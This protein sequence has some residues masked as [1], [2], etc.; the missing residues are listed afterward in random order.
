MKTKVLPFSEDSAAEAAEILR[1]GGI[2]GL[3]TETVY[4]LAANAFDGTAVCSVFRAKGRPQDNPLIVHISD[5][6]MLP[7]LVEEIPDIAKRLAKAFWAGPL[8]MV[9]KKSKLI[10]Y[11]T[12]GGLDTVAVRMPDCAAARAIINKCGFPLA[13][14][15]A[16][17]SGS[18]SPTT[19][20]HVLKDMD[21]RIPLIIDGGVCKVGVESTVV[22]FKGD[23]IHILRPGGIT[24]EMLSE[25]GE[26]EVD[27]AVTERLF[28]G[29]K[30][31]SPGMKYKHYSPRANVVIVDA[32]GER[33]CDYCETHK[34][35]KTLGLGFGTAARGMF[36]DCGDTPEAQAH[37]LFSLLREAD[38]RGADTVYVEMPSKQGIGLAVYNR[39]L[40][41]AGFEIVKV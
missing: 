7:P 9:F 1:H 41:A 13:A 24:P 36:L 28:A 27:R 38:E 15:S 18:P 23:K 30:A 17:L 6:E 16:N 29:E 2:V 20:A 31:L 39:L 32:H 10:P 25:F 40:R 3:P 35:G 21:G 34:R 33:F 19:A 26:T 37:R 14:P 11:E 4:G 22:C 5:I 8:T 12:S